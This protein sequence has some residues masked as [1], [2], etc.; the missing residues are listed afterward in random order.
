MHRLGPQPIYDKHKIDFIQTLSKYEQK[1][2]S[3]MYAWTHTKTTKSI[4]TKP[5]NLL[6]QT[7]KSTTHLNNHLKTH[8]YGYQHLP[9]QHTSSLTY[10]IG[11]PSRKI[12][13]LF[14]TFH[15]TP[16][17]KSWRSRNYVNVIKN[18]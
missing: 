14:L 10:T 7:T 15:M 8:R 17:S 2:S 4:I 1:L 13:T 9:P 5:Q 12:H 3:H 11:I 6:S 18:P 16:Q